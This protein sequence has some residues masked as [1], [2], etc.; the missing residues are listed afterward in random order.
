MQPIQPI[1]LTTSRAVLLS[2]LS[3]VTQ[4]P[5]LAVVLG[6]GWSEVFDDLTPLAVVS[7]QDIPAMAEEMN[8]GHA[9][10]LRVYEHRGV[11]FLAW[12]GRVH[13]YQRQ[14]ATPLVAPIWLSHALGVR[15]FLLT[16]AA[17]GIGTFD[18]GDL[19]L[20]TGHDSRIPSVLLGHNA[21][22][23][24]LG[25]IRHAS[26]SS[27]YHPELSNLLYAAMQRVQDGA[28][29]KATYMAMVGPE[30]EEPTQ[31]ALL[32]EQGFGLVG[33]STVPEVVAAASLSRIATS[34]Q[35]CRVA[36]LSC[37][38]NVAAQAGVPLSHEEVQAALTMAR[39]RASATLL[40]F[41]ELLGAEGAE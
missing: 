36:A 13:Y 25:F 38:T 32:R 7:Y 27:A 34:G 18:V 39:P 14:E 41:I 17:G 33:M 31:I 3:S 9:G 2:K 8:A 35:L 23:A 24:E 19:A 22:I 10:E 12:C 11:C 4:K 15:N 28:Q 40:R 26:M 6:S 20:I 1:L 37:V 30:Y 16:N 21:A 5:T 29:H